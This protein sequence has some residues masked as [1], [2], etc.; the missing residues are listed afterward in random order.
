MKRILSG[1]QPT[2]C[3]HL[4]NYL[5]ALKNWVRLQEAPNTEVIYSVVDL[6]AMTVPYDRTKL[7]S[8]CM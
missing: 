6:H 3:P 2:G 7:Q 8:N 4:G 1:I 5:G